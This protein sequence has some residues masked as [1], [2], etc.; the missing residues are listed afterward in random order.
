MNTVT[1][2]HC[3]DGS[4]SQVDLDADTPTAQA[5]RELRDSPRRYYT[6]PAETDDVH[7]EPAP[8]VTAR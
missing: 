5:L 3:A 4:T 6:A 2:V 7:L 1:V 8:T